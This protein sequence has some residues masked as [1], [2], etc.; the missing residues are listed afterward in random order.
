MFNRVD[1]MAEDNYGELFIIELQS[2]SETDYFLRMLYGVSKAVTEHMN[3][4]D[5]YSRI[6]K[7]YHV[8]IVYFELGKGLD[9]VYRGTNEFR[10]IHRNDVLQLTE[11]Q[12]KFFSGKKRKNVNEVKDLFPEYYVLCVKDFD[13]VAKDN[14]DEWMYYFK[15]NDIPE[16]FGAP[17]LKEARKRL[18]FDSLSEEEKLAYNHHLNQKQFEQ[19]TLDTAKFEGIVEGEAIGF[20]KGLEKGEAIGLEKGEAIGLEKGEAKTAKALE[21]VVIECKRDGLS[22]EQIQRFTKLTAEQIIGILKKNDIL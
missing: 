10:G 13:D 3:E 7:V 18:I 11:R 16:N 6:R 5:A 22:L 19:N 1:I 21:H 20:E 4:G 8:N 17:G 14:L 12:K 2:S 15:N 9:Y